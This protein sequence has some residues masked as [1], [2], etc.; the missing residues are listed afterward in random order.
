LSPAR[1]F[2][3]PSAVKMTPRAAVPDVASSALDDAQIAAGGC[4]LSSD[5]DT[6]AA[7]VC[8]PEPLQARPPQTHHKTSKRNRN[9]SSARS[10]SS[11]Q[12]GGRAAGQSDSDCEPVL[13]DS[14]DRHSRRMRQ[15]ST[16]YSSD[17]YVSLPEDE[18]E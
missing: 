3:T 15:Q 7:V 13:D 1:P 2:G 5:V 9:S 10:T 12:S 8:T 6:P 16:W 17:V 14:Q 11:A 4:P 18:D